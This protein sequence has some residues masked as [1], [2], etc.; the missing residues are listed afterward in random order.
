MA[1]LP[2]TLRGMGSSPLTRGKLKDDVRGPAPVRLIPAHAGKTN[3]LRS[4]REDH[5][6]HPRSRGENTDAP[7]SMSQAQGSSPLTRGKRVSDSNHEAMEG[8][9]PAHAGK[10]DLRGGGAHERGAHPRS[11]GENAADPYGRDTLAGSSPLTRGKPG[12]WL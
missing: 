10:T 12:W 4:S 7:Y 9:I 2:G 6:A 1:D 11:R 8:L 5:R 3:L